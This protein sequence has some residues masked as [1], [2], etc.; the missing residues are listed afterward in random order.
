MILGLR[1][2]PRLLWQLRRC[3][4]NIISE[5]VNGERGFWGRVVEVYD[6]I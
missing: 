5:E 4:N 1:L 6:L 3:D 2:I